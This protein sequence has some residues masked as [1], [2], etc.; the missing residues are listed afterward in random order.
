MSKRFSIPSLTLPRL[1]LIFVLILV[2]IEIKAQFQ[3][4]AARHPAMPG[5]PL[6]EIPQKDSVYRVLVLG[7]SAAEG[8]GGDTKK[9]WAFLLEQSLQD[10]LRPQGKTAEVINLAEGAQITV[11]SY[12]KLVQEGLRLKPDLVILYSGWNDVTAFVGNPGWTA[13]HSREQ[14]ALVGDDREPGFWGSLST[15]WLSLQ[16]FL[17]SK[18]EF[19]QRV[20]QAYAKIQIKQNA[21]AQWLEPCIPEAFR[22]TWQ[23]SRTAPELTFKEVMA[24]TDIYIP[25]DVYPRFNAEIKEIYKDYYSFHLHAFA[26]LLQERGIPGL[27]IFQPDLLYASSQRSL[28]S[29]ELQISQ[30]LFGGKTALWREII[31]EYFPLA[32]SMAEAAA[33]KHGISFFDLNENLDT[34]NWGD[35]FMDSVHYTPE[36]NQVIAQKI[37]TYLTENE[38]QDPEHAF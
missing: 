30:R 10:F 15:K 31:K 37:F 26:S 4:S 24:A 6:A 16:H 7:G 5:I 36:G 35:L 12:V 20:S 38:T 22:K 13:R 34:A 11:D 19:E 32:I 27:F 3:H 28:S 8:F 9:S 23:R 21:L 17:E 29:E 25:Y 1:F 18:T 33:Q 14:M 2:G